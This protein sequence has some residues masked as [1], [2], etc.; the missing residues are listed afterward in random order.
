MHLNAGEQLCGI[1]ELD[2]F[3]QQTLEVVIRLEKGKQVAL[4]AIKSFAHVDV[5]LFWD[6][7]G[8]LHFWG[9]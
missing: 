4:V 6:E 1:E 2:K 5:R 9:Q 3:C 7:Q 8:K